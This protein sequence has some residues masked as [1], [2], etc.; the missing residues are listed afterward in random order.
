MGLEHRIKPESEQK[1]EF[2]RL[3]KITAKKL[4]AF[5]D[6]SAGTESYRKTFANTAYIDKVK[7]QYVADLQ[8]ARNAQMAKEKADVEKQKQKPTQ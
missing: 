3:L 7:K 8:K 2:E 6:I 5:T 1:Q 4:L